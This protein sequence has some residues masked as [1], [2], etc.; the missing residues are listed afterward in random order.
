MA[1]TH[2]SGVRL[3]SRREFAAVQEHGRRVATRYLTV[4]AIPN[5]LGEDRLGIIASRRLGG[6]VVRN[7]AKRRIREIFRQR[8]DALRASDGRRALD[9]VVIPKREMVAAP[10]PVVEAEFAGAL[11]RLRVSRAS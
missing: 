3:R 11:G 1:F 4:L 7:R 8:S 5:T 9:V 10:F 6:A 2:G